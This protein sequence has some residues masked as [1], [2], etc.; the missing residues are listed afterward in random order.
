MMAIAIATLIRVIPLYLSVWPG[1]SF[2]QIYQYSMLIK[3]FEIISG[4]ASFGC[5]LLSLVLAAILFV[6]KRDDGMAMFISFFLIFYGIVMGGPLEALGYAL[7]APLSLGI[8]L[9]TVL[10]TTPT[11]ILFCIFPNGRF[12]PRWTRWIVWASILLNII[13]ILRPDL[14]WVTYS[15]LYTQVVAL[16]TAT[17]FI[18]A[19]YAQVYR[20]RFVSTPAER[21][22]TKWVVAGLLSWVAWIVFA[23]YPWL[24][25]QSLPSGIPLP[26][27]TPLTTVGWWLSLNI[28]PLSL[29][30]AILRYRLFD[31]DLIIQRTLVY[32]LLTLSL[33][34]TF[35]GTVLLL[36]TLFHTISGT[37]SPI[38][39]VLSTLMI[40]AL[41]NP[42]RQRIQDFIDRRFY[43]R[44]YDAEKALER[45][46]R[47]A[48]NETDMQALTGKLINIVNDTV[49]PE[50]I[51]VWLQRFEE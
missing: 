43:R 16:I 11:L 5:A 7:G 34:L 39:I 21:Q 23:M 27:W 35:F 44:R 49:Q 32:S 2:D 14:D 12:V 50:S 26:W 15:S 24:Y 18:L 17:L 13:I 47:S 6:R 48:S 42:L 40:A 8:V 51:G 37:D 19:L 25:L 10:I 22:Q 38:A 28:I 9:Q 3:P 31:I 45:F 1:L 29:T 36:Q 4:L 46:A 33:G 20:F 41:F 30:I